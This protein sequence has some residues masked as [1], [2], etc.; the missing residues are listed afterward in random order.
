MKERIFVWHAV[1]GLIMDLES[2]QPYCLIP[3][4]IQQIQ[5]LQTT[6]SPSVCVEFVVD[7][8]PLTKVFIP[9]T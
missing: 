6:V 5:N 1:G 4:E 9:S 7:K 8:T 2:A 3:T